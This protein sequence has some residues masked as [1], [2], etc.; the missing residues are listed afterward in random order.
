MMRKEKEIKRDF[1]ERMRKDIKKYV[2]EYK[3]EN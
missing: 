2:D 1:D 3:K